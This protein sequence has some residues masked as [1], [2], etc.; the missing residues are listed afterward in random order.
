M[1][2]THFRN[3]FNVAH[4]LVGERHKVTQAKSMTERHAVAVAPSPFTK[5]TQK[6]ELS[7]F[8][9]GSYSGVVFGQNNLFSGKYMVSVNHPSGIHISC[10]S[11]KP[12]FGNFP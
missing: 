11:S 12:A 4:G 3:I 10:L 2:Q 5:H 6:K 8:P 7:N 9:D 1:A